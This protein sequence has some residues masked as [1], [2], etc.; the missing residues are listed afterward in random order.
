MNDILNDYLYTSPGS[1]HSVRTDTGCTLLFQVPAEVAEV[2]SPRLGK[3]AECVQ[4]VFR[5]C[6]KIDLTTGSN[7]ASFLNGTNGV[8]KSRLMTAECTFGAGWKSQDAAD[9]CCR[10]TSAATRSQCGVGFPQYFSIQ[11]TTSL[12]IS[13]LGI[14]WDAS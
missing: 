10:R 12:I 13:V 14:L 4:E 7:T 2:R 9:I 1:T 3:A 11:L 6:V 5:R 8:R